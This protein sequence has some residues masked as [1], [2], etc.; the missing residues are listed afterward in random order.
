MELTAT[1]EAEIVKQDLRGKLVLTRVNPANI[2]WLLV[3]AFTENPP[4]Q[5]GR[6]WINARGDNGWAFT[7]RSTATTSSAWRPA[8][9]RV[10]GQA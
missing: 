5:V 4:L 1:T 9:Y 6:Q 10:V 2:K 3:N 8:R 7:R